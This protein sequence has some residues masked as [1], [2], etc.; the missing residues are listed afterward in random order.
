MNINKL[1]TNQQKE[2]DG[3]WVD[4]P[5]GLRLKVARNT[6]PYIRKFLV[7]HNRH[8]LDTDASSEIMKKGFA[9][10]VLLGW[11]NLQ[12]EDG[13]D[14]EYSSDK[15]EELF[16]DVPDFFDMV[17]MYSNDADLFKDAEGN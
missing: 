12:G 11:Q 10:H 5:E 1:K 14:I 8:R 4:G 2:V 9:K 17:V 7:K 16:K 15:A 13:K 6:N 3:V